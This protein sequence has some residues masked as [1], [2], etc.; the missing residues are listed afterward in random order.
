M[1]RKDRRGKKARER[2]VEGRENGKETGKHLWEDDKEKR[3]ER[4][5]GRREGREE[6]R[7]RNIYRVV[8]R[9]AV[10][11]F[12]CFLIQSCMSLVPKLNVTYGT[13]KEKG[14]KS[15]FPFFISL[16]GILVWNI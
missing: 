15:G 14:E 4:R 11:I 2:E 10:F 3:K 13:Q 16:V 1:R 12:V 5:E 9:R 6:E 7:K 8:G